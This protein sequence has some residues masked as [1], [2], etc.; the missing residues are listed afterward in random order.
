MHVGDAAFHDA[1][2]A[3]AYAPMRGLFRRPRAVQTA[4]PAALAHRPAT[5]IWQR[6]RIL[7][8]S[9]SILPWLLCSS[10]GNSAPSCFGSSF[11]RPVAALSPS[12][13]MGREERP[14]PWWPGLPSSLQPWL[15]VRREPAFLSSLG[16]SLPQGKRPAGRSAECD[17]KQKYKHPAVGLGP[18][19][20]CLLSRKG[21][22]SFC[23]PGGNQC[24]SD[25]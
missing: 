21:G 6:G 23:S 3:T 13:L 14:A 15:P 10:S 17:S 24:L 11:L 9:L 25:D 22:G 1:R 12:E 7:S 2:R 18:S 16:Q 8:P 19:C 4:C 5:S 20:A